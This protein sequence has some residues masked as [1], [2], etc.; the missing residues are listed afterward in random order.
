MTA[1]TTPVVT[2]WQ[3]LRQGLVRSRG[4]LVGGVLLLGSWQLCETLVPVLIGV[5]IDRAVATGETRA[6]LLLLLT[7]VLLF[8]VLGNSYRFGARL[9]FAAMQE[10]IHSLRVR[11]AAHALRPRGTRSDLLPGQ[12]LSLA[13]TDAQ[14]VGLV[15]RFVG[16]SVAAVV[17]ILLSAVLLFR[18]DVELG[19]VV[20][21]GVPTVLAVS[22]LVTPLISRRTERQQASVADSVGVA[23]DLVRGLRVLKGIGATEVAA[24]RYRRLSRRA[25]D[26]GIASTSTFGAMT[27]LTTGLSGVFL[28]VV[29]LVAGHKAAGGQISIGELVAIVGLTQFLAEPLGMLGEISAHAARSHAAAARIAAFFSSPPLVATGALDDLPADPVLE[30]ELPDGRLASRPGE[31]LAVVA[32]DPAEAGALLRALSGEDSLVVRLGGTPTGRL[33]IRGR[34]SALLVVPHHVDLFEGT[35]RGNVDPGGRLAE[36]D[37]ERVLTAAAAD[38]V[39]ALAEDGL[40]QHVTPDGSTWSGGQRQRVALARALATDAPVLVLHDPTTAVDAV[41]E[42]RIAAGLRRARAGLTTWLVTSSPALLARAD[43]V[44]VLRE[45]RVVAEG[46]HHELTHDPD[47]RRL[48]LR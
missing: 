48:V 13:T 41:T 15:L 16:F 24:R 19:L 10:E 11:I 36:D 46:E 2:A 22:Q 45:G 21:L 9:L 27:G 12:T 18:I 20:L 28:A 32:E 43:R 17:S 14:L 31:L 44:V 34:R 4:R 38:D 40:D 8:L 37:L 7:L 33:T 23:T 1:E 5:V 30:V 39:V 35:L 25:R 6:L 26:H 42:H 29:A 3:I 47:Y